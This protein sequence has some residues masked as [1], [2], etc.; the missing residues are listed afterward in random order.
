MDFHQQP[1]TV[2]KQ[3]RDSEIVNF[4]K[5]MILKENLTYLMIE[6]KVSL[7]KIL[8]KLTKKI[9]NYHTSLINTEG[10]SIRREKVETSSVI[11]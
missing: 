9:H 8:I 4:L 3:T 7:K 1:I 11:T 6:I 5:F 2:E 10:E